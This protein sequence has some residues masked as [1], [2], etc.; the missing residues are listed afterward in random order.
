MQITNSQLD[1]TAR[2]NCIASNAI[3][4]VDLDTYVD[5]VGKSEP[6]FRVHTHGLSILAG[7]PS[8]DGQ[9]V[10][11]VE[12]IEAQ[13]STLTCDIVG[14]E[15]LDIEWL[16]NGQSLNSEGSKE[17]YIQVAGNGRRLHI[18]AAQTTDEGRYV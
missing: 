18:L 9:D 16:K 10:Q 1:D 4:V 13:A 2:Y 7:P 15:P 8:I 11:L 5:V 14:T 17:T 6:I 12:V 3:G